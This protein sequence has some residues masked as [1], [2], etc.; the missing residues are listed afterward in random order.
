MEHVPA[1]SGAVMRQGRLTI[2]VAIHSIC[3]VRR[4]CHAVPPSRRSTLPPRHPPAARQMHVKKQSRK[5]SLGTSNKMADEHHP[6]DTPYNLILLHLNGI[7]VNDRQQRAAPADGHAPAGIGL[8]SKCLLC[9]LIV[10][11]VL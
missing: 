10:Y 1:V 8:S 5:L 11:I 4:A 9:W 6:A 3:H 2:R 7:M